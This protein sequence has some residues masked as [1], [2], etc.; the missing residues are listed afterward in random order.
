MYFLVITLPFVL[1][2][3]GKNISWIFTTDPGRIPGG[4]VHKSVGVFLRLLSPGL[5]PHMLEH[6][7]LPAIYQN[8]HLILPTSL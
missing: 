4:K 5:S 7:E 1:P 2:E 8:Y 6:A 3:P